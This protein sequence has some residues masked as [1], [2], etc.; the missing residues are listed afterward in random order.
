MDILHILRLRVSLSKALKS[1]VLLK[2]NLRLNLKNIK[3]FSYTL[4]T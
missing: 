3:L 1:Y 4:K 2:L